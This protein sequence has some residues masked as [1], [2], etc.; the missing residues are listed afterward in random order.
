MMSIIL[1]IVITRVTDL[2]HPVLLLS[3]TMFVE[4][5]TSSTSSPRYSWEKRH[6]YACY[7]SYL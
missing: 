3:V 2:P 5:W 6:D 4:G 7:Y 1:D